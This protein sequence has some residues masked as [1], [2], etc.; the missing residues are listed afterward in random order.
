M[1][2]ILRFERRKFLHYLINGATS[3]LVV[4]NVFFTLR[5]KVNNK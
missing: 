5:K 1:C 4:D 3:M 2:I